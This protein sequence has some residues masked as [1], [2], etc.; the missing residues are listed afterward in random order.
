[1]YILTGEDNIRLIDPLR[2]TSKRY[3]I[4]EIISYSYT[5]SMI[6]TDNFNSYSRYK[7]LIT[8]CMYLRL[9]KEANT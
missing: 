1:M 5:T 3:R 7:E 4:T 8:I 2:A 9:Q 6:V